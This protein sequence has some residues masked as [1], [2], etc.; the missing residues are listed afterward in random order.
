MADSDI[1]AGGCLVSF[2]IVHQHSLQSIVKT[3][4][5]VFA[6]ILLRF[7]HWFGK[8]PIGRYFGGNLAAPVLNIIKY[9]SINSDCGGHGGAFEDG[10]DG[11]DE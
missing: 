10:G 2:R 8:D 4:Q 9:A 5:P 7:L 3:D 1:Q 6:V 11:G